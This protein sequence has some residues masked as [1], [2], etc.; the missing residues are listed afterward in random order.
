MSALT[1]V[2]ISFSLPVPTIL[3]RVAIWIVL[4]YRRLRY[5]Y[6][7]RRIKLTRGKYAIVDV[8][9]FERLNKYKWHCSP[10]GYAKR[11]VYRSDD[12]GKSQVDIYM[13]SVVCPAPTGMV[14]DHVNRNKLDNRK[15]N[16]RPATRT[17]NNWNRN[18]KTE[19]GK[20]RY[21]GISW[22]KDVKKW[23][24]RLTINGRRQTFG[25]YADEVEAAKA[26]DR[27]AKKHRGQFAALNFPDG[28]AD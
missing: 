14:T 13:H 4:L 8:E 28:T 22:K 9:D 21:H 20:T 16:L 6:A 27:V 7:F 17:Q 3:I 19:N 12:R 23:R 2:D 26:Y 25:Y 5:G 18:L 1:K 10:Y 24:V 15:A 11:S